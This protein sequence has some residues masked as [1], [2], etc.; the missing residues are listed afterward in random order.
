M[1]RPLTRWATILL[2]L[3]PL[4]MGCFN[5]F[6]PRIAS[7]RGIS[8][9]PPLPDSPR[10]VMKLFE[11]CWEH[12]AITEYRELFTKDFRFVFATADST[13]NAYLEHGW[14]RED[15]L[16]SAKNLFQGG[17]ASQPAA[18]QIILNFDANL[19]ALPDSR[20][21]KIDPWHKEIFTRVDLTIDTDV[22]TRSLGSA[23]FFV[24]RGDSAQ[25]PADLGLLPD[26]NRWYIER[27]EEENPEVMAAAA[28]QERDLSSARSIRG[29]AG[30]AASARTT[31]N[32]AKN[33][34]RAG[35]E[36]DR[37]FTT[38]WDIKNRYRW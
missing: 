23:R 2:A 19:I 34:G 16:A 25:I 8:E 29:V 24:V 28:S 13:G 31:E 33:G 35:L 4:L 26:P 27:Y 7:N 5:P 20:P 9:P 22:T 18:T 6:Q 30:S 32:R 12:R 36:I 11:W 21:G 15:E 10:G 38:W 17:N 14:T 37:V 3:F 1:T